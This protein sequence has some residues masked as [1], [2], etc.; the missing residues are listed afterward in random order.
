MPAEILTDPRMARCE[1]LVLS[2]AET[3]VNELLDDHR[4]RA[5]LP[6]VMW[7]EGNLHRTGRH[8]GNPHHLA[9][10]IDALPFVNRSG[11]TDRRNTG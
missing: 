11:S 7:R 6:G 8:S 2:E 4:R 5:E 1:A 9:P 3:R 10:D